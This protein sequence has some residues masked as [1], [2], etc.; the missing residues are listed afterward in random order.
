MT[1]VNRHD[2]YREPATHFWMSAMGKLRNTPVWKVILGTDTGSVYLLN[3]LV[4]DALLIMGH[5]IVIL[6]CDAPV[7]GGVWRQQD[8]VTIALSHVPTT[9]T[10]Y[11]DLWPCV[12]TGFVLTHFPLVTFAAPTGTM[13]SG[14]V[15][16]ITHA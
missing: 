10:K 13:A 5:V 15:R 6:V 3:N 4:K 7:V 9:N 12:P 11:A 14:N 2:P 8:P 16:Q 1:H